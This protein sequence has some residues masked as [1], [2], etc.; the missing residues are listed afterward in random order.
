MKIKTS[1]TLKKRFRV[2]KNNKIIHRTKGAGHKMAKRRNTR[3]NSNKNTKL[4]TNKK[5]IRKIK[6]SL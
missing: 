3:Q 2:T 4:L 6:R 5:T 1:K